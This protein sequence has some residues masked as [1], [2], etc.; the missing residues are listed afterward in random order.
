MSNPLENALREAFTTDVTA[1]AD[2]FTVGVR[3]GV[4]R[5]RQTRRALAGTAVATLALAGAVIA[6]VGN[7]GDDTAPPTDHVPDTNID[8]LGSVPD[9]PASL[10]VAGDTVFALV[11]DLDCDCS[12]VYRRDDRWVTLGEVPTWGVLN[13]VV[14]PNGTDAWLQGEADGTI[15]ASH[16]GARTW[17]TLDLP[18]LREDQENW[19]TLAANG[20][21]AMVFDDATDAAWF[22]APGSDQPTPV[23]VSDDVDPS[24]VVAV[25]DTFVLMPA[26]H[27]EVESTDLAVTRDLGATWSTLPQPCNGGAVASTG[28]LFVGCMQDDNR[29]HLSR[30]RPDQDGFVPFQDV[31]VGA[32]DG[33]AAIDDDRLLLRL[34]DDERIITADGEQDITTYLPPDQSTRGL[35]AVG[36]HLYLATFGAFQESLDGGTTWRPAR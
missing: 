4:R 2:R 35:A 27:A 6:G 36:D 23:T 21:G 24:A 22:L 16:D 30:W 33:Y 29:L 34:Q 7:R 12:R 31:A 15:W 1:D 8:G 32:D 5:R 17:A 26:L 20:R 9:A 10:A 11:N 25:G 28:A 18:P 3:A 14:A 19:R 13:L